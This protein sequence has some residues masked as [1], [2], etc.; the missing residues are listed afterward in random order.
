MDF[1]FLINCS[2]SLYNRPTFFFSD[3]GNNM[4]EN[5]TGGLPASIITDLGENI[6]SEEIGANEEYVSLLNIN[7]VIY[8]VWIFLPSK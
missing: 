4:S 1:Y 5:K 7:S 8:S 6:F 2:T 3:K